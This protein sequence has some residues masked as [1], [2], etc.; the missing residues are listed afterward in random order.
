MGV[1][2]AEFDL[3][4]QSGVGIVPTTETQISMICKVFAT[5]A[6]KSSVVVLTC[7]LSLFH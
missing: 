2:L 7:T 4:A 1:R 5:I 3:E 6:D